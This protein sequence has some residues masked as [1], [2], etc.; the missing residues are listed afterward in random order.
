M[1]GFKSDPYPTTLDFLALLRAEAG[2][3][4]EQL[5]VDLIEKIT[6]WD[7]RVTGSEASERPDG[8][9]QVRIEVRAKKLYAA[10]N[11]EETEAPL[12]Q[13]IDIGLFAADLAALRARFSAS[14]FPLSRE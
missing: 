2:P 14:G 1:V 10:G 7:L 5:I 9:W 8:K 12:D 6:L 4:H 13:P 11:G 3:T